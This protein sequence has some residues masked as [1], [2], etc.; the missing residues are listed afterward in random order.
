[1]SHRSWLLAGLLVGCASQAP[2]VPAA[3]HQRPRCKVVANELYC[4]EG[5]VAL[6]ELGLASPLRAAVPRAGGGLYILGEAGELVRVD[7]RGA[8][9]AITPTD[10][11]ALRSVGSLV[12]ALDGS[13][14]V[15]CLADHAGDARCGSRAPLAEP[16][17]LGLSFHGFAPGQPD[18][19]CGFTAPGTARCVALARRCDRAC[20]QFPD[21]DQ[22]LRCVDPCA[23]GESPLQ[24]VQQPAELG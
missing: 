21:C 4:G 18:E 10:F 9:T 8:L 23:A 19:L 12:C 7:A 13:G 11:V 15:S 2:R 16:V 14:A 22:P 17:R 3:R 20:L 6:A 5:R 1:M 24:F